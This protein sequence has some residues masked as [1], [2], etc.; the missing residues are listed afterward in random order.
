MMAGKRIVD[1]G[2]NCAI[3]KAYMFDPINQR[4]ESSRS[5]GFENEGLETG[6]V[7][8]GFAL[9]VE[10]DCRFNFNGNSDVPSAPPPIPN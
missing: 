6:M 9:K 10:D 2:G 8:Y 3:Q 7:G 4:W 5:D 1:I